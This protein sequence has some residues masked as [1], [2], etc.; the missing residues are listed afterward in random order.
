MAQIIATRLRWCA[1]FRAGGHHEWE[2]VQAVVEIPAEAAVGDHRGQVAV[3]G[4]HQTTSTRLV[5][6]TRRTFTWIV[7]VLPSRSNSCLGCNSGGMSPTSSKN[8]VPWRTNSKRPIFCEMAPVKRFLVAEQFAL[9]E[10][11]GDGRAVECD[12]GAGSV[13]RSPA[14]EVALAV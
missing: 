3:G 12:K 4:R 8:S 10:P 2:H 5:A 7:F 11:R 9:Q 6:G 14:R 1:R 13:R